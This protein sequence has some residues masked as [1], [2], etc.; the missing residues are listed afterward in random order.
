MKQIIPTFEEF[1][2]ESLVASIEVIKDVNSYNTQKLEKFFFDFD[3]TSNLWTLNFAIPNGGTLI[4]ATYDYFDEDFEETLTKMIGYIK[5]RIHNEILYLNGIDIRK[6]FK[7]N[8]Q[9][10]LMLTK[11]FINEIKNKNIKAIISDTQTKEGEKAVKLV[12]KILKL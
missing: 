1:I 10:L 2:Y 5:F 6:D 8:K 11:N 7:G 9:I 3:E 12:K 4:V